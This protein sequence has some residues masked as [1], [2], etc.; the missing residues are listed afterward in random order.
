MITVAYLPPRLVCPTMCSSTPMAL[1]ASN[2]PR[3]S[4]STR[5]PSAR[6]A[7]LAVLHA[8]ASASATPATV[9][10]WSTSTSNTHRAAD[11]VGFG[12]G[13]AAAVVSCRHIRRQLLRRYR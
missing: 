10:C 11:L 6:T 7:S 12:L 9:R 2:W 1:T 3:S 5:C 4:L 13:S 8:T